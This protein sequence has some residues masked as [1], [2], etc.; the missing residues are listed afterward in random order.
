VQYGVS[1]YKQLRLNMKGLRQRSFDRAILTSVATTGKYCTNGRVA[2]LSLI[3]PAKWQFGVRK[4]LVVGG[5]AGQRLRFGATA[6]TITCR[7]EVLQVRPILIL[8]HSES[9]NDANGP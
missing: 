1:G 5:Y 9:I 4:T 7:S 2:S 3:K 6:I 8:K